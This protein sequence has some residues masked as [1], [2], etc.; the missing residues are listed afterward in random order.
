[1]KKIILLMSILSLILIIPVQANNHKTYYEMV[2]EDVIY[3]MLIPLE[4]KAKIDY[5]GNIKQSTFCKFVEVKRKPNLGYSYEM[6][7]QFI[8]FEGAHNSPNHLF[9]LI[10]EN[11]ELTD[12]VIKDV[13]VKKING[14]KVICR[15]PIQVNNEVFHRNK[16]K[17][18]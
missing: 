3:T 12:W 15:K 1:M 9:T 17:F 16:I 10:V 6:T 11:V 13:K 14:E 4:N 7:Y 5:F 18:L 2:L 8:T